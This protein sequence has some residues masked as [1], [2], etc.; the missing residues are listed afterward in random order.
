MVLEAAYEVVPKMPIQMI[1]V[2][3][4]RVNATT[5]KKFWSVILD[6]SLQWTQEGWGSAIDSTSAIFITPW[7]N[8]SAAQTSMHQLLE[9]GYTLNAS[10]SEG[11]EV[12]IREFPSFGS[13][14]S[15]FYATEAAV[16][17]L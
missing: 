3:L 15:Y 9:F 7:L 14:F 13:F 10:G 12:I 6:N 16:S 2:M 8:S 4:S 5:T 11:A 1:A 17:H